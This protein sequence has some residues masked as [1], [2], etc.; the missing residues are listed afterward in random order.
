VLQ[1]LRFDVS[2]EGLTAFALNVLAPRDEVVVEASTNT[3]AVVRDIG[4]VIVV[5]RPKQC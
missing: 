3:W 1:E 4:A 2:R 5:T